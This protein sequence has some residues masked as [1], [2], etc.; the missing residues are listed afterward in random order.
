MLGQG[1]SFSPGV[2]PPGRGHAPV[3]NAPSMLIQL[4]LLNSGGHI[5]YGR[6]KETCWGKER[7]QESG[8]GT[9]EDDGVNVIKYVMCMHE[10]V[11]E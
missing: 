10:T 11:K 6:K 5:K 4:T 3:N 9:R 7:V 1:A 2:Q 8:R